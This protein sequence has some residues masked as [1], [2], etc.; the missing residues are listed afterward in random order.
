DHVWALEWDAARKTLYVGTGSQGKLFALEVATGKSR[1]MWDSGQKHLRSLL[2]D[3]KGGLWV[4]TGDEAILF[5]VAADGQAQAIHDFDGE[6]VRAL[7][8]QDGV[9]YVAVNQFEKAAGG[10]PASAPPTPGGTR[11]TMPPGSGS[12][13]PAAGTGAGQRKGRGSVYRLDSEGRV[14]QL[15]AL[16]DGYFTALHVENDR[17]VLA[18]SGTQGK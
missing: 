5:R 4:G 2:R 8:L 13:S 12:L 17:S 16:A 11:I 1:L 3:S 14:E 18:A 7:A 6:E 15:H 10:P 9:L